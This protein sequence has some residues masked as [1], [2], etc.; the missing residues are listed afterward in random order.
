M[1]GVR[2]IDIQIFDRVASARNGLRVD[3]AI[4]F[5]SM[6]RFR[7]T[8][9][10]RGSRDERWIDSAALSSLLTIDMEAKVSGFLVGAPFEKHRAIR[11]RESMEVRNIDSGRR[12]DGRYRGRRIIREVGIGS[13]GSNSGLVTGRGH[14]TERCR[15][16]V[17]GDYG[18]ASDA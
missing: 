17:D 6:L 11:L 7:T 12:L 10:Q 14:S 18:G 15:V 9:K 8:Q 13:G 2:A 3:P 1:R 16:N 5:R 4:S